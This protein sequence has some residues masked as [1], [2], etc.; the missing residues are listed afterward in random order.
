MENLKLDN[1]VGSPEY[2]DGV[3]V[4]ILG[5]GEH[6]DYAQ[7]VTRDKF[8]ARLAT[9]AP[10][11]VT[12]LQNT[13]LPAYQTAAAEAH[14]ESIPD[15]RE[16][17]AA[18]PSTWPLVHR[19]A[20]ELDGWGTRFHLSD[21][22]LLGVALGTVGSWHLNP[23]DERSSLRSPV[24]IVVGMHFL[25][26]FAVHLPFTF[27][28]GSPEPTSERFAD[29]AARLRRLLKQ[30]HREHWDTLEG[31]LH[32]YLKTCRLEAGQWALRKNPRKRE[33]A[34]H[35]DW[36]I[37]WQ[38]QGWDRGRIG[39]RYNATNDTV[40]GAIRQAASELGLTL[41]RRKGGRPHR[42]KPGG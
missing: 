40:R 28:Y 9:L 24:A 1:P 11:V 8:V 5:T 30:A 17:R 12:D 33:L 41:R 29:Y 37:H 38:V 15:L 2:R 20:T 36:L 23:K 31:E 13:V 18:D 32:R 39:R 19:L 14:W 22:W 6:V 3:A 25:K 21:E 26:P 35:L 27:A 7:L 4:T 16:C 42:P 34:K 10:A